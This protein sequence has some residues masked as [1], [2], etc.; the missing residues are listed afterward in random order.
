MATRAETT[1]ARADDKLVSRVTTELARAGKQ[2]EQ[3]CARYRSCYR[4]W[5]GVLEREQDVW[6]SQ[7]APKYAFQKIDTLI[8]N[9]VDRQPKGIV[10][11]CRPGD[12]EY[13]AAMAMQKVLNEFR[14]RDKDALTQRE[15]ITQTVV[16][17][18]S[19]RK[20][21]YRYARG[22]EVWR[23]WQAPAIDGLTGNPVIDPATK[24]PTVGKLV[25]KR[26]EVTRWSQPAS[27]VIPVEDFLWDPSASHAEDCAWMA[28]TFWVT[29]KHLRDMADAGV[30]QNVD[31]AMQSRN[32]RKSGDKSIGSDVDRSGRVMVQ[33]Y[34]E[35]D[36]I[37]TIANNSVLLRDEEQ[38]Y[39]HREL[40]FDI[41]TTL[42][43]LYRVDG[44]SEI[45]LIAELQAA[46]WD[47][48]NQRIDN[49]RFLTNAAVI[50]AEGTTISEDAI[51][52]GAII[53]VDGE[54][55]R[56]VMPWTPNTSIIESSIV[57]TQELKQEIDDVT[58]V[59]P[60]VSGAGTQT[61][62]QQTAT[63]IST[64][65]SMAARRLESKRT[66]MYESDRQRGMQAL[67]LIQQFIK[68]PVDLRGKLIDAQQ[69][70]DWTQIMP[71]QIVSALLEYDIDETNE[72]MDRQQRRQESMTLLTMAIQAQPFI[73]AEGKVVKVSRSMGDV[74]ESF[75]KTAE[76]YIADAPAPPAQPPPP[77][78]SGLAP[79]GTSAP[80]GGNLAVLP[81]SGSGPPPPPPS[82]N[83]AVVPPPPPPGVT[84]A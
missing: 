34:W 63:Q 52:P 4:S 13:Q 80:G 72:S 7:L 78:I 5:V 9:L 32:G 68:D 57:A 48:L 24:L 45:E 26:G 49:T 73:Q 29:P 76:D 75:D 44:F 21:H 61:L 35:R 62:D 36:R 60:Y 69:G 37:I 79:G 83:G 58:G 8:A 14:R 71:Q 74:Y 11:P 1:K 82:G 30:Y 25:E 20:T 46:L 28:A 47:F 27:F 38:P 40:P 3:R 51:F 56:S 67:A 33:E 41:S 22:E 42:P 15:H 31:K 6:E 64:F 54:P 55:N 81:G 50:V 2:H 18:L 65:Q 16:M 10:R 19:P 39:W 53:T 70:Y 84:I 43:D 12:E 59:T 77:D 17:G 66:M 23:Q